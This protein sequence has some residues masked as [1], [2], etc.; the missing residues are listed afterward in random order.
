M[1]NF[2]PR[3]KNMDYKYLG[4]VAMHVHFSV[5]SHRLFSLY[6]RSYSDDFTLFRGKNKCSIY[7]SFKGGDFRRT[8]TSMNQKWCLCERI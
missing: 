5:F 7:T 3:S 2:D 6:K 1:K 4:C 8:E